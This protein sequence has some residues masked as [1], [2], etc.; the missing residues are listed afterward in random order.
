MAAPS[1]LTSLTLNMTSWMSPSLSSLPKNILYS[2]KP[3]PMQHHLPKKKV[4]CLLLGF[5]HH[6]LSFAYLKR[7][8]N[9]N[10]SFISWLFK[11]HQRCCSSSKRLN[12]SRP[13]LLGSISC[14]GWHSP[15]GIAFGWWGTHLRWFAFNA[16]N[17]ARHFSLPFSTPCFAKDILTEF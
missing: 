14:I 6:L 7:L 4:W 16:V 2:P 13:A 8:R 11:A 1:D 3:N 17:K 9:R 12:T 5:S 15:K 10:P